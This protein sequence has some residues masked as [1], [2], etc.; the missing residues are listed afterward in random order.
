ML[1]LN[2]HNIVVGGGKASISRYFDLF[3]Q[4]KRTLHNDVYIIEPYDLR[5]LSKVEFR[6]P[7]GKFNNEENTIDVLQ[8]EP[9]KGVYM[10]LPITL[11]SRNRLLK[12]QSDIGGAFAFVKSRK[13][14]SS[15]GTSA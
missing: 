11:D 5:F 14:V 4:S 6:I 13:S 12:F 2:G 15:L 3:P 7:F 1:P 10:K 9:E 8:F